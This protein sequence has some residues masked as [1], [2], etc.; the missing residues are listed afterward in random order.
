LY[1]NLIEC[2]LANEIKEGGIQKVSLKMFKQ[3]NEA[4]KL[5]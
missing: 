5:H 1:S 4:K 2:G 3:V